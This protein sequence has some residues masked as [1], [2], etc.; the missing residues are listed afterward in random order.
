[1]TV[2][3]AHLGIDPAETAQQAR[4]G[5]G[6]DLPRYRDIADALATGS[7]ADRKSLDQLAPV[8]LR[9]TPNLLDLQ[10]FYLTQKG[11]A[12]AR[13]ATNAVLARLP[14]LAGF[15]AG[16]QQRLL[17][18][19][20]RLADLERL[21]ATRALLILAG[22]VMRRFEAAKRRQGAYDFDDLIIRTAELLA[23]RSDAQWVLFKLDGGIEHLLVD[24]AQD[25]SPAQWRIV[26]ALTQEFFAGAGRHGEKRRTIFAVGD[27]K[28]S[29]YSF[30]GADPDIF[31][32]VQEA[33]ARRL[34]EAGQRLRD[35]DFT[36]SFRSA[37]EILQAVDKV[38][39][40]DAV[41]RRG[42][43]GAATRDWVHESNR[44]AIRGMVEIWPL[45]APLDKED[46]D[47]W[48]APVDREPAQSPRRRLAAQL[49][50]TIRNWIG[51][52]IIAATGRTVQPDDILV[53]VQK[54]NVFFDA[55][56]RELRQRN[57]PVAGADRLKLAENI[58]V[59]DLMALA[60][61]CLMPEDDHA[62]ACVL[63]SPILA[64]PLG[65]EQLM[66]I[67]IGRGT[68]TLWQSALGQRRSRLPCRR[69][70]TRPAHCRRP[71]AAA[72]MT[73]WPDSWS[74]R[75]CASCRGWA[76]RPMT[77][78]T[79]CS[80]RPCASRKIIRPRWRASPT[81]SRRAR[82]RSSATWNRPR[83]RCVS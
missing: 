11:E 23:T 83:A 68:Q 74:T 21:A 49:A 69:G 56:I 46:G 80:D 71:A 26:T 61:F 27:R 28:Q 65:E 42:L 29:I 1:M 6:L 33:F 77:R 30:Q 67:A 78:W 4:S 20:G 54:R 5:L 40:P 9:P 39:A 16:E 53:L 52:R 15:A 50:E 79:R 8:L 51:R 36:V 24:E 41:A 25:T 19:L 44:R 31:A 13:M 48:T 22:A 38:F 45:V 12:R 58:A 10:T 32:E 18:A 81:G 55:L 72:P 35:V 17:A 63:K 64:R 75:A 34:G 14:W 7:T 73:S 70:G 2:L 57:V 76:A 37:P 3:R 82:P 62:L 66:A 47:V 60:A 59:Q 43:D